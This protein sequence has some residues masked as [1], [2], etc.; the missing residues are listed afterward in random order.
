MKPDPL[1]VFNQGEWSSGSFVKLHK[2]FEST[3]PDPVF[4]G[5]ASGTRDPREG[6]FKA[7]SAFKSFC[8]IDCKQDNF[9]NFMLSGSQ[10]KKYSAR[11][12]SELALSGCGE[13]R[14]LGGFYRR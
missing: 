3:R 8:R 2:G 14:S 13:T 1:A 6:S 11:A 10:Y 9:S 4:N 7:L 12:E 5:L